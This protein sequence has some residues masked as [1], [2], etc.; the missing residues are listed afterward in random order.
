MG[1]VMNWKVKV[2]GTAILVAS[3]IAG[4]QTFQIVPGKSAVDGVLGAGEWDRANWIPM[5]K[6]YHGT[7]VDLTNAWWAAM[8]DG[9]ENVLYVGVTGTDTDRVLQAWGSWD[10]Q[11]GVELY[12][13]ARNDNT[14]GYYTL[15]TRKFDYAQQYCVGYDASATSTWSRL[16]GDTPI[17]SNTLP[18]VAFGMVADRLVYEFKVRPYDFYDFDNVTNST[19]VRLRPGIVVGLDVVM[20]TRTTSGAFG[21]LCENQ[22]GSKFT[23]AGNMRDYKLIGPPGVLVF[24]R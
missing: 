19:E 20:S 22:N 18:C 17:S 5:N 15:E 9:S 11:D 24:I 13:N 2:I 23:N 4:A 10:G 3:G 8:W 14:T 1:V 7:P 6:I 16:G 21:M 12:I